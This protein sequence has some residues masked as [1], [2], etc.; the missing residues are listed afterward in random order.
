MN[1]ISIEQESSHS[2]YLIEGLIN[3]GWLEK[4]TVL[5]NVYPEYSSRLTQLIN[6]KTCYL[7]K[8]ELF[9]QI[10]LRVP[11]K[12]MNQVFCYDEKEYLP[13]DTYLMNWVNKYV[14]AS[15]KFLFIKNVIFTGKDLNKIRLVMKNKVKELDYVKFTSLYHQE[16]ALLTPD[17]SFKS[18]GKEDQPVF[19]WQNI[20]AY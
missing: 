17:Y 4:D 18:F 7:N 11:R 13:F 15:S 14:T 5:V 8:N 6:Q 1:F 19:F 3:S 16:G 2:N 9:E 20:N 10:T 12:G